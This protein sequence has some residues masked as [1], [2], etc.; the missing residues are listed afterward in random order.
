M[1]AQ[2][3]SIMWPPNCFRHY[4]LSLKVLQERCFIG[5]RWVPYKEAVSAPY[6]TDQEMKMLFA[7][8]SPRVTQPSGV[9][10][11]LARFPGKRPSLYPSQSN[12]LA[13]PQLPHPGKTGGDCLAAAGKAAPQ[14]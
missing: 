5:Q 7:V 6:L 9:L 10:S 4:P 14:E 13:L 1:P 12:L 3:M 11:A 8:L 2:A